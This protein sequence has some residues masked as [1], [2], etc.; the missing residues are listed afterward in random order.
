MFKRSIFPSTLALLLSIFLYNPGFADGLSESGFHQTSVDTSSEIKDIT[1]SDVAEWKFIPGS[2]STLSNDGNWFAYWYTPNEGDSEVVLRSTRD[3][4]EFRWKVGDP[5]S[6]WGGAN[7]VQFSYDSKYLA[8]STYPT[9]KQRDETTDRSKLAK[10]G[11]KLVNVSDTTSTQYEN[12]KNFAFSGESA[13]WLAVHLEIPAAPRDDKAA[14]SGTNMLLVE[15]GAENTLSLGNVSEFG[16]DKSGLWLAWIVD[17]HGKSGN[18]LQLRNMRTGVIT[19]P[20]SDKA[21][22]RS[23]NWHE[24]GLALAFLKE[25]E[26]D[27]WEDNVHH[28]IGI[29]GFNRNSTEKV[30]LDPLNAVGMPESMSVSPNRR[31]YWNDGVT[32]LLFGIHEIK[33]K[34]ASD[35]KEASSDEDIEKD[36]NG[37]ADSTKT[38]IDSTKTASAHKKAY[39]RKEKPDLV[40]WHWEDEELQSRQQRTENADKNFSWLSIYHVNN[41]RFVR[42]A[43]EELKEVSPNRGQRYGIG[44]DD[45]AYRLDAS[46]SGQTF[47]DIYTVDFNTGERTLLLEKFRTYWSAMPV[48]SPDGNRIVYH[49]EGHFY[50][51]DIPRAITRNLTENLSSTFVDSENDRNQPMSATPMWGWTNDSRNVVLRDEFG[52]WIVPADGSRATNLTPNAI[53][54]RLRHQYRVMLDPDEKGINLREPMFVRVMNENTKETGFVRFDNGRAG[55]QTL[56]FGEKGY[57]NLMKARNADVYLFTREDAIEAPDYHV[58]RN[59]NLGNS[60]KITDIYPEKR[61]YRWTAGE[62]LVKYV[63]D[64]GDSLSGVLFLPDGYVEGEAYPTI[65]YIYERLSQGRFS[66]SRPSY[67]GAGFNRTMYTSN[68]YAVFMPDIVYTMN[69]PGMSAVW[70]VLPALDAAIATGIVDENNV[71]IHGHSWGGYQ[72]SFLITQTDRFKAAVAGAPL[73]NMI[74]MYGVIYWNSGN[75]NGAIFEAS[76]GRLNAGYWELWD[77]YKRNSPVYF[78]ER[79]NTPLLLMHNDKDGAVDFTQGVEYYNVL[80]RLQKPVVMLQYVGE[81][82]GLAKRANQVD[83]A[84]RM[85]EFLDHHLKGTDAP[86]WYVDGVTHLDKD[87]HIN[88]RKAW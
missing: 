16:F 41:G 18:G 54:N 72:T 11:L 6:T 27:K 50:S 76:Q 32:A 57:G 21:K 53:Q 73:T 78:V 39:E 80:R 26:H 20:E 47:S 71:A 24:D 9:F 48:A 88:S 25:I 29:R 67:P 35:K 65:V 43:D 33:A 62:K 77:A 58:S 45:R 81:N 82:H 61:E 28:V 37:A 17:A 4:T 3:T 34:P 85:M 51:Y 49:K 46:L 56:L 38:A 2:S 15:L 1:W 70:S 52:P 87:D 86:D 14:G 22:Y 69:D 83:Y 63:T 36:E 66:H 42:L 12:V 55:A 5:G 23:L 68:G 7:A 74:S 40:L 60:N 79:V 44:R 8:F 19:S 31:P 30:V 10:N 75:W 64:K 13:A 84:R 59:R